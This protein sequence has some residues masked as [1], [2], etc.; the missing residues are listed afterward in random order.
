MAQEATI[1]IVGSGNI[2]SDLLFK[3]LRSDWLEPR[4]MIGIRAE[5]QHDHL[6]RAGHDPHRVRRESV[7]DVP[8]AE[9]VASVS[10]SSAGPGTRANID[11]FTKTTSRGV[12]TIG[13][14]TRGKAPPEDGAVPRRDG[15]PYVRRRRAVGGCQG[16]AR[17]FLPLT[18]RRVPR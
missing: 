11:E 6:R 15:P 7:V 9:T 17:T 12:E 16:Q 2:S 3:L 14:A 13:G 1:A 18:R 4:W 8:Y 10:S 5:R